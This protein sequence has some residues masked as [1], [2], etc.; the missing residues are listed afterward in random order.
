[1]RDADD[2][3]QLISRAFA[4]TPQ[5]GPEAL[6][7]DHCCE[8]VEVSAAYGGKRGWTSPLRTFWLAVRRRF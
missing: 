2:I 6:F 5:P 4:E 1:M 7:N 8:C 3:I